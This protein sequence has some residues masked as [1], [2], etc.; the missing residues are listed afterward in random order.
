M[1]QPSAETG[2]NVLIQT[3]HAEVIGGPSERR[4][5]Q[6]L[7]VEPLTIG[8]AAGISRSGDPPRGCTEDAWLEREHAFEKTQIVG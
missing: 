6:A 5:S 1:D 3:P 2:Y 4:C 8:R 7:G